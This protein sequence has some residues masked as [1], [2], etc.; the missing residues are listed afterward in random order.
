MEPQN[1]TIIY[2]YSRRFQ[3]RIMFYVTYNPVIS[4]AC[5]QTLS[6]LRCYPLPRCCPWAALQ[7]VK[8]RLQDGKTVFLFR[9]NVSQWLVLVNHHDKKAFYPSRVRWYK[10]PLGGIIKAPFVNFFIS[11]IF[12][13]TKVPVICFQSHSHFTGVAAAASNLNVTFNR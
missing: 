12:E 1:L 9:W 8:N 13:L 6:V 3:T 10:W 2:V 5:N 4:Q 11:Q 7:Y